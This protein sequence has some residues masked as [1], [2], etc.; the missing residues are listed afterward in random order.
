M[1]I[2]LV[3]FPGNAETDIT[4]KHQQRDRQSRMTLRRRSCVHGE[5]SHVKDEATIANTNWLVM[6]KVRQRHRVRRTLTTKY[7]QTNRQTDTQ[8]SGMGSRP[9]FSR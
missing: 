4:E 2:S 8:K 3:V 5:W 6:S 9:A 7:L 1:H